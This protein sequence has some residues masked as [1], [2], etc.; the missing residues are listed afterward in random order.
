VFP[1]FWQGECSGGARRRAWQWS[2]LSQT[3]NVTVSKVDNLVWLP[4][5]R[6]K[7]NWSRGPTVNDFC[8]GT[9][10]YSPRLYGDPGP[11]KVLPGPT[12]TFFSVG[13]HGCRPK[14]GDPQ[15]TQRGPRDD[16]RPW[17]AESSLGGHGCQLLTAA[18][19]DGTWEPGWLLANTDAW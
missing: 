4:C 3:I 16:L 11:T 17:G 10:A 5:A 8:A 19:G 12:V 14:V 1:N 13:T 2:V 9:C 6:K 15:M 18:G 7:E